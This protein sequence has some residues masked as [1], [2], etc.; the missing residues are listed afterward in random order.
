MITIN[1]HL[2]GGAIINITDNVST[3][4]EISNILISGLT[5][6]S[7]D[8]IKLE[9]DDTSKIIILSKSKIIGIELEKSD[10]NNKTSKRGRPSKTKSQK[11]DT[12]D[13]IKDLISTDDVEIK[14]Q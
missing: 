12:S 1:F 10:I 2:E 6:N 4:E 11:Q 14:N 7:D 3:V 13:I 5:S 9:N 8:T